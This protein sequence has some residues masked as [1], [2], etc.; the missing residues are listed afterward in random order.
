M[1]IVFLG[2]GS[3]ASVTQTRV[4]VSRAPRLSQTGLPPVPHAP[5]SFPQQAPGAPDHLPGTVSLLP[6]EVQF[7]DSGFQELGV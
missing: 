4:V 2:D 3:C 7:K 6:L 1:V 5:C